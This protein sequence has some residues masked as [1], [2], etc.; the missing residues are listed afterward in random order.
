MAVSIDWNRRRIGTHSETHTHMQNL[1]APRDVE[2]LMDDEGLS[3]C[4]TF[5]TFV[6][7]DRNDS[8]LVLA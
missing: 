2:A 6:S 7:V 1:G 4:A 8:A 3:F 5:Y